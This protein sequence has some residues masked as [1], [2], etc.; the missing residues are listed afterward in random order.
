MVQVPTYTSSNSLNP[1][2]EDPKLAANLGNMISSVGDTVS[3]IG[4]K[5]QKIQGLNERSKAI[6]QLSEAND[7]THDKYR[8]DPDLADASKNSQDALD[9][10]MRNAADSIKD[11]EAR[12]QFMVEATRMKDSKQTAI[13]TMIQGR[14]LQQ[15]K[16]DINARATAAQQEYNYAT[17]PAQEADIK[18]RYNDYVDERIQSGGV[19]PE[20]A[21]MHKELQN[22][23]FGYGKALNDISIIKDPKAADT[24]RKKIENGDYGSLRDVDEQSALN[25]LDRKQTYL[26]NQQKR[27]MENIQEA[28][29]RD[30]MLMK[31]TNDPSLEQHAEEKYFTGQINGK[32]FNQMTKGTTMVSPDTDGQTYIEAVAHLA[33]GGVADARNFIMDK[34]NDNKLSPQDRD[35]LYNLRIMPMG[36]KYRSIKDVIGLEQTQK[37]AT[38]NFQRHLKAS[39]DWLHNSVPFAK[40]LPDFTK[41]EK[42]D[43]KTLAM[44]RRFIQK[45]TDGN[46]PPENYIK[47]AHEVSNEQNLLDRPEIAGYP[48]NGQTEQDEDGN[49]SVTTPDGNTQPEDDNE[50]F[51]DRFGG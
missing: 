34:F 25:K 47:T 48:E 41:Q 15:G 9:E 46:V 37:D 18:K 19:N 45:I 5:V 50:S 17:S 42:P 14:I 24:I 22:Y 10:N 1:T 7:A 38:D 29:A 43:D 44:T 21:G 4:E 35:K 33:N 39:L 8:T 27:N 32:T 13:D 16:F 12:N 23:N 28:N 51:G 49:R 36:D 2:P 40:H 20:W 31:Q 26:Q 6:L 30:L 3:D 11:P